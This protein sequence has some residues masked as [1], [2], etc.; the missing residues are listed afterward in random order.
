MH[1]AA[2]ALL[3]WQDTKLHA[4]GGCSPTAVAEYQTATCSDS[5][6]N[7]MH[8]VAVALLQWQDTKLHARVAA[9]LLAVK[10]TVS[11]KNQNFLD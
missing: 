6:P 1:A 2:V 5:I 4:R 3:Q 9:L 7:C 8:A 10:Q 11:L